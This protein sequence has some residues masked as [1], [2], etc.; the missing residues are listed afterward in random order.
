MSSASPAREAKPNGDGVACL[1]VSSIHLL[2]VFNTRHLGFFQHTPAHCRDGGS[3]GAR[4]HDG[5]D[6]ANSAEHLFQCEPR[7]GKLKLVL[8]FATPPSQS[9]LVIAEGDH[10]LQLTPEFDGS[11]GGS[12]G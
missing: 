3:F 9:H 12:R 2:F 5:E 8:R 1:D 7:V 10:A 4:L 11:R 6:R